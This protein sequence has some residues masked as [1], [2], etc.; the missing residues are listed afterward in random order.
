MNKTL[1]LS[2]LQVSKHLRCF[3]LSLLTLLLCGSMQAMAETWTDANGLTWSFTA[4]GTEATDIKFRGGPDIKKVYLYGDVENYPDQVPFVPGA[5]DAAAMRFSSTEGAHLPTI[6]DDVYFGLKTLI[7]DVSDVTDNFDLKVMNG[8]WSNTY[9]DHVKWENGLNEL[10]ITDVMARECAKGGEGRDLDLML[11][12]GSMTLNAVYYESSEVY[13]DLEIPSKVYVGSTELTV[14]SIGN[15]ALAGCAGLTSVTIP[16]GVTSIGNNALAGC[17]GLTSVTIPEGVT[18]IGDNAFRSCNGLTSVAI[19]SSVTSIGNYA[20]FY[21]NSLT[22][23]TIPEGVTTIGNSVF[24]QCYNLTSVTIPESVTSIGDYAFAYCSALKDVTIP[25]SVTNIGN[26]AFYYCSSYTGVTIPSSVKTIGNFAFSNCSLTSVTIP[27]SV[28]S[29]GFSPFGC[30]GLTSI[31]VESGNSVYDSRNN[32][33]AIIETATNTLIQGCNNTIIP[34]SVTSIGNEAFYYCSGLTSVTIPEGVTSIGNSAFCDCYSLTSVTIP[35]SVTNIGN[36]AFSE[37]TSLTSVTIPEGV[38]SIGNYAFFGCSAL[39]KVTSLIKEPFTIEENVFSYFNF[40]VSWKPVFT[41]ATLYVPA[42]TKSL[43]EATPAWNQFQNIVEMGGGGPEPYAV[44]SEGNTVLTFYY[45]DQKAKRNGMDVGPF[46]LEAVEIPGGYGWTYILDSGWWDYSSQITSAVFDV[47][48]ANC[49]SV[50]STAYWFYGCTNLSNITGINNLNTSNVTDA[51]WMFG[52]CSSL[53]SLALDNFDTS[54]VMNMEGMFLGCSSLTSLG[55]SHFDT[56]NVTNM[57][58]MFLD[59]SSLTSLDLSNFNTN[60]VTLMWRMFKGCSSLTSLDVS[61]FNTSNVTSMEWMF[62]S[63]SSLTSLDL[64]SF[65]TSNV[66]DMHEMFV[67]CHNLNT[68]YA[69][70]AKWSTENVTKSH[71]MFGGCTSLIGGNGTAY[72]ENH[73]DA[74]YACIDKPGQP[75]YFTQKPELEP[76]EVEITVNSEN[77]NGQDLTDNVVDGVYYNLNGGNSGYDST[78]GSIVIGE[79]TNMGQITNPIPGTSDVANNFTGLILSVAAGKGTIIVNV[80]TVGNA[81][82]VVQVGNGT[83][84]IA[85]KAEQGDVV[86]NYDVAEDTYI[87]I[88]AI[89]G[90]SSAPSLRAASDNVVKIYGITVTP[91]STGIH[92]IDNGQL[93]MDNYYSLDGRKIVGVP[94]QKGVYIVNGHKVVKK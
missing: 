1:R 73:I 4:N 31:S 49:T 59:C 25:S 28:T 84:M 24:Y 56:S 51:S 89:I 93:T 22:S 38:T 57:Y 88:Y 17:A 64:G 36:Y 79:T 29:I 85:T 42:G 43:Y 8:W 80:K 62:E 9:Y 35:S 5:W 65:N 34:E 47:S 27:S 81:Q 19:P 32:C 70:E 91:E 69:D 82:L 44:L 68:I 21:C 63:C 67:Y 52:Y 10:Q 50:T 78:D 3:R 26:Y 61:H 7:F 71:G 14:T 53:K 77:L 46:T 20:F 30:P 39:T 94:T 23:V 18:S 6:P 37:C 90:S 13:G 75:G 58:G 48:F 83:P 60:N 87:Y 12:S 11:Y 86:V 41:S 92:S 15:G 45:D 33:N 66:T 40:D 55:I 72:D 16:E 2:S 74:E 76:I 54:N